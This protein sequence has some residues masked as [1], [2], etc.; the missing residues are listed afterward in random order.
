MAKIS[1]DSQPA[2]WLLSHFFILLIQIYYWVT[3]LVFQSTFIS[4]ISKSRVFSK[5]HRREINCRNG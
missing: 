5:I 1:G 2:T 4:S 3:A